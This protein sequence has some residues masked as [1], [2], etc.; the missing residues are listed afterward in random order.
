M[1]KRS[2][3]AERPQTAFGIEFERGRCPERHES[4]VR[5]HVGAKEPLPFVKPGAGVEPEDQKA[6]FSLLGRLN[7]LRDIDY[8]DAFFARGPE[9]GV[10]EVGATTAA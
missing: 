7:R 4:R 9:S 8:G 1:S 3:C 5:L 2:R 10:I 6:E